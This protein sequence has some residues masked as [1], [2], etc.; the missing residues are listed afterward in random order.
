MTE[1]RSR[2]TFQLYW[3]ITLLFVTHPVRQQ[4]VQTILIHQSNP[5]AQEQRVAV[6]RH[7]RDS[8]KVHSLYGGSGK[9]GSACDCLSEILLLNRKRISSF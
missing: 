2:W 6:I 4:S 1:N 5:A 8:R 3:T 7:L 9:V